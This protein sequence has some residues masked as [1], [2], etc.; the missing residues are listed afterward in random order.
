[1]SIVDISLLGAA[2]RDADRLLTE[3]VIMRSI[4]GVGRCLVLVF[5]CLCSEEAELLGQRAPVSLEL[6]AELMTA[7]GGLHE[8]DVIID[9]AVNR[10]GRIAVLMKDARVF[11][12]RE[13]SRSSEWHRTTLRVPSLPAPA[14]IAWG[15]GESLYVYDGRTQSISIIADGTPLARHWAPETFVLFRDMLVDDAGRVY[16]AAYTESHPDA[17]IHVLCPEVSC[18]ERGLGSPRTVEDPEAHHVL[19]SGYVDWLPDGD[20]VF[21]R[22]NPLELIRLS[23][24]GKRSDVLDSA[25]ILP[26]AETIA[27][28]REGGRVSITNKYPQT[29]GIAVL[30]D[31][32]ILHSSLFPSAPRSI[33]RLYSSSGALLATGALEANYIIKGSVGGRRAVILKYAWGQQLAVYEVSTG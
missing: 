29:T 23:T 22:I 27:F 26:D 11:V 15:P 1:M 19:Q 25:S 14:A 4:N 13:S 16:V 7:E 28:R 32:R 5:L 8:K 33:V 30:S 10:A 17:Q 12:F 3:R 6:R 9:I 21:A 2:C 20:L 24:D 31:G 18:Y